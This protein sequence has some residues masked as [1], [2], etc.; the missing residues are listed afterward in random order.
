MLKSVYHVGA[1]VVGI[2]VLALLMKGLDHDFKKGGWRLG[3]LL[4]AGIL[5]PSTLTVASDM[6]YVVQIVIPAVL[7]MFFLFLISRVSFRRLAVFSAVLLLAVPLGRLMDKMLGNLGSIRGMMKLKPKEVY[8]ALLGISQL[9]WDVS[10]AHGWLAMIWV[11][12]MALGLA[13]LLTAARRAPRQEPINR[14]YVLFFAFLLLLVAANCSAMVLAGQYQPRYFIP[15]YVMPVFFGWPLL[16]GGQ[17]R[18]VALLDRFCVH[19]VAAGGASLFLAISLCVSP[20]RNFKSLAA[21]NDYYPNSIRRL[22]EYARRKNLKN[23]ISEYWP[24]KRV[25]MLS[26]AGLRVSQVNHGLHPLL[27]INSRAWYDRPFDFVM[28][29]N[30]E[31]SRIRRR[32]GEPDDALKIGAK[33]VAFV[34]DSPE[35]RDQFKGNEVNARFDKPNDAFEFYPAQIGV[36]IEREIGGEI[37]EDMGLGRGAGFKPT[38]SGHL[39]TGPHLW[40]PKGNYRYVIRASA[41]GGNGKPVGAWAVLV[42]HTKTFLGL[43]AIV[44]GGQGAHEERFRIERPTTIEFQVDYNGSGTLKVD[45]IHLKR[46]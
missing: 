8:G 28:L 12:F 10:M 41:S 35:F 30:L 5:I 13:V 24:A 37:G 43:G 34:Y 42:S 32:F 1:L 27:W 39:L 11:A 29:E 45:G 18:L 9:A 40:L 6:I 38:P 36:E 22:D 16:L 3:L 25:T 2:Y 19:H 4:M 7:A 33:L 26:K 21:W 31:E 17:R 46:E 15:A 44:T 23:G 20:T 14:N